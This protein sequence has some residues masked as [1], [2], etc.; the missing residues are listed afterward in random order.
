MFDLLKKKSRLFSFGSNNAFLEFFL[1]GVPGILQTHMDSKKVY[2]YGVCSLVSCS[3][4][5][6]PHVLYM[7]MYVTYRVIISCGTR[8]DIHVLYVINI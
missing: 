4:L 2:M 7:Y 3:S 6:Y 8:L 1:Q 5:I